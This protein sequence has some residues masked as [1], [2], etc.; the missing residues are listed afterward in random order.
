MSY[1][2]QRFRIL[3]PSVIAATTLALLACGEEP[4]TPDP[5]ISSPPSMATAALGSWTTK[6]SIPSPR[7]GMAGAVVKNSS[8]QYLF[9]A[10]GGRND[11]NTAMRRVEAYNA[12]TNVWTR[13]ANLP[14]D[15]SSAGAAAISGKIYVV[16]GFNLAGNATPTLYVYRQSTNSW[17]QKASLPITTAPVATGFIGGKLYVVANVAAPAAQRLYVYDPATNSWKRLA[18][19]NHRHS[20]GIGGVIDGKLYLAWGSSYTV[21]VYNPATNQWSTRLTY[22]YA[23]GI[24]G[25]GTCPADIDID[26]S[27]GG[28]GSAV[29]QG[30]LWVMGGSNDDETMSL[31]A[32]YDPVTNKWLSKIPMQNYRRSRPIGGT[33]RN[34]AG[35][36]RI[37][38]TGG[39]DETGEIV[40]VTEMYAP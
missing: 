18:D 6:A 20:S 37:V 5:A 30:K 8:G 24:D 35:L 3:T 16:G 28:A 25:Q 10:I 15:R 29:F 11:A 9:Y 13:R 22:A 19:V 36:A 32:A 12:A 4:T 23:G 33:V 1:S 31:V 14:A 40:S 26:C 34:A 27:V 38:V 17:T 7:S 2:L 21:D 39:L